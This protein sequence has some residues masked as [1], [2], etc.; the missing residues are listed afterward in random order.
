MPWHVAKT[1]QCPASRPWGVI[2]DASGQVVPGGCHAT[3]AEA[4]AHM[5]ALY[6]N[7]PHAAAPVQVTVPALVTIPHV[8]LVAAGTWDL[9]TGLTTFTTQ[10]L[11]DAVD[12]AQ[13]PAVGAPVIKLGHTDKRFNGDGQPSIGRVRNL[14]LADDGSKVTGDLAGMPGWLGVIMES[15][16]PQRS[17]EGAWGFQC[18]IGHTHPFVIT[19]LALLGVSPP[20]VGVLSDIQDVAALYGV[21]AAAREVAATW[22]TAAGGAMPKDASAAAAITVDD[23]RQAYYQAAPM[24]YWITEVQM[25]PTQ[26]IVCDD[27]EGCVYRVPFKISNGAVTFGTPVKVEV[28]Y[29]DV[30]ALAGVRHG[31]LVAFA[32]AEE[33]RAGIVLA[34][35]S[36]STQV[37]NMGTDPSQSAINKMFA[38]PADT[39]S[40]SKLPHHNCDASSHTVGEANPDGCSAAIGAIN[41][42]HGGLAGVSEADARKAYNH[43]AAHLRSAGQE[44]PDYSGPGASASTEGVEAGGP[45]GA[46]NGTH[47]H[48]H[49]AFGAQGGDETHDH[50]H[51]HTGGAMHDHAHASA[52]PTGKGAADVELSDTQKAA[53]R[54]ALGLADDEEVTAEHVAAMA[55]KLAE[56]TAAAAGGGDGGTPEPDA[57]PEPVAASK[58]GSLPP[59]VVAV[60]QDVWAATQARIQQGELARAEQLRARRDSA[61]AG[62]VSAGKFPAARVSHWQR[63]W[64]ADPEGT[65]AVLAGLTPGVVPTADIGMEGGPTAAAE[66]EDYQRLFPPEYTRTAI[67]AKD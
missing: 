1:A 63:I 3:K 17:V 6:A 61:I 57:T 52:G 5:A 48:P 50:S 55:A 64:D 41:G 29:E 47:S 24:S 16:Y 51:T 43:L 34:A 60:D 30:A 46:Y 26:L 7:E 11:A 20:G 44:P 4:N 13:C 56:A 27:A 35:W 31:T 18:Q 21:A 36:A 49:S 33:S 39:K 42:A 14:A 65:E 53:I 32:S 22:Q 59:G 67:F 23:V 45:H 66:A 25:D 19:G 58:A 2:L 28:V 8:D 40:D 10:D 62:A 38:L 54:A 9:S 15:A 37:G 12:A